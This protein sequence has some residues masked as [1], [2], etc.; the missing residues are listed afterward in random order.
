MEPIN[1]Q[2]VPFLTFHGNAEEAMNFYA[3]TLPGAK[4]EL[5]IPQIVQGAY[6]TLAFLVCKVVLGCLLPHG[7][8]PPCASIIYSECAGRQM[9]EL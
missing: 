2:I 1:S 7:A 6:D 4:I 9:C 5:L 3:T 8:I